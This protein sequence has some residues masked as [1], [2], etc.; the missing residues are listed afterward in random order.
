MRERTCI[1]CR[2]TGQ[3]QELFRIAR[4]N[5]RSVRFDRTGNGPGRGAYVC[6]LACFERAREKGKIAQALRCKVSAKALEE[7]ANDLG[8]A[9]KA[10]AK[11]CEGC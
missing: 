5:D 1:G 4:A 10:D 3:K 2:K 8:E 9:V 11:G 6:S 7:I